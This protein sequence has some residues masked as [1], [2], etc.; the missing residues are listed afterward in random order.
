MH[1]LYLMY[2]LEWQ[3][4]SKGT[5]EMFGFFFFNPL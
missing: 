5:A 1:I 2:S 3:P 4:L